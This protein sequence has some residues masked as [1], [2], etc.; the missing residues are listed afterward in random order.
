MITASKEVYASE[1]L[2][3]LDPKG[4]ISHRLY[5]NSCKKIGGSLVKDLSYIGRDLKNV[6]IVDD[7]P[8]FYQ[9]QPENAIQIRPFIV[10]LQDFELKK[11][12]NSFFSKCEYKDNLKDAVTH[13]HVAR[14]PGLEIETGVTN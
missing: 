2:N 8:S 14:M 9:L 1:V 10:D 7:N 4:L 6:V 3:K 13:Y 11:L 12:M 5:G